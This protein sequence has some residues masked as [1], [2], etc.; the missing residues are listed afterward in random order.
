MQVGDPKIPVEEEVGQ[1]LM[2]QLFDNLF[3]SK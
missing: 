3:M 2:Q 1:V